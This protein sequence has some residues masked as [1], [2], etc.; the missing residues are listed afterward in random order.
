MI[1]IQ[2]K[3]N[4]NFQRR[5]QGHLLL[6]N[7]CLYDETKTCSTLLNSINVVFAGGVL[8]SSQQHYGFIL[9]TI[10]VNFEYQI[11]NNHLNFD[12]IFTIQF[13]VA[14]MC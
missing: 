7:A 11:F 6:Y 10:K 3:M 9:K 2:L 1:E 13:I 5:I 4:F 14:K 8:V 12:K